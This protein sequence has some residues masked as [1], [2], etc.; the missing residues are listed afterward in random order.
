MQRL[1]PLQP[2]LP[3]SLDDTTDLD[4]GGD[5]LCGTCRGTDAVGRDIWRDTSEDRGDE[6]RESGG[7]G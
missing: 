2:Q 6:M 3:R 5:G 7:F 4:C 1:A